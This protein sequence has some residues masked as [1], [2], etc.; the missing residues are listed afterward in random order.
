M[1][2]I[3]ALR[4]TLHSEVYSSYRK[5]LQL[6]KILTFTQ[7]CR[8][9]VS[10]QKPKSQLG[11][12]VYKQMLSFKLLSV[13]C[14]DACELGCPGELVLNEEPL[15]LFILSQQQGTCVLSFT[16]RSEEIPQ[17]VTT[18]C[19]FF[20]NTLESSESSVGSLSHFSS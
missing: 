4:L 8:E 2:L 20:T 6:K 3:K 17:Y 11:S 16:I 1:P 15:W 12:H 7:N 9:E 19:L 14:P 10:C 18:C 13:S 5:V